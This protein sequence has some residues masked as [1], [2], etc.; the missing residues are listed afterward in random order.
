MHRKSHRWSG[1]L[2][3]YLTKKDERMKTAEELAKETEEA[4]RMPG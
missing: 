3:D 1:D 2:L 4:D